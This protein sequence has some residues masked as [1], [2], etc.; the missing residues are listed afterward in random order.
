MADEL[1]DLL[2][3]DVE[4]WRHWLTEHADDSDGV[5]LVLA[6][7]WTTTPTSLTYD[8]ALMEALCQ[9]WIDGQSR[10]R[11]EATWFQ[12]FTPRRSRSIWSQRNVTYVAELTEQG[13]MRPRGLAEVARAQADGRWAAA[14]AGPAGIE[15]PPELTEALAANPE[16]QAMWEGLSSQNRYAILHRLATLK[17]AETRTRRIGEFVAMLA[18]GETVYPQKP[19]RA[20]GPADGAAER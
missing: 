5:R 9:G 16:A 1:P 6:K 17:R 19:R 14:Y 2:L 13:R 10:R 15:T 20:A 4:A 11:D 7:K 18:R 3:P 12:R 8:Q